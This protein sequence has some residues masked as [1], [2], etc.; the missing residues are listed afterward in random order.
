MILAH[1]HSHLMTPSLIISYDD[2]ANDRDALVLGRLFMDAGASAALAYVRHAQ[3]PERAQEVAEERS[4]DELLSR[5]ARSIGA[6]QLPRHVV[7]HA[8]TGE[9]LRELALREGADL[10]VFGSD[11]RTAAGTV[12]PGKSTERLLHGGPVAVALA[13]AGLSARGAAR[14]ARIGVLADHGDDAARRT[15]R[16]LATALGAGIAGTDEAAD[17]LV[18]GSSAGAQVGRVSLTASAEYEIE[19][20]GVP[21]LVLPRGVAVEFPEPALNAA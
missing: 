15:A 3:A 1:R 9:G 5:G 8:S 19:T 14:V 17:L 6:S 2:T 20:S 10:I 7:V 12:R 21:V 18:V 11:Y 4:A 13:P 16:S